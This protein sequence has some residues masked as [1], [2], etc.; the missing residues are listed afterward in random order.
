MKTAPR[1]ATK[2]DYDVVFSRGTERIQRVAIEQSFE[3]EEE[4]HGE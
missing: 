1:T 2:I 3:A 4:D